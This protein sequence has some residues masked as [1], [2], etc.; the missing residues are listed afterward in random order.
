MVKQGK[1]VVIYLTEYTGNDCLTRDNLKL[2]TEKPNVILVLDYTFFD[3]DTKKDIHVHAVINKANIS[4]VLN[5]DV[6]YFGPANLSG[7]VQ[8]YNMLPAEIRN[9]NL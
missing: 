7:F 3:V 5:D 2:L 9:M 1:T 4:P 8:Y 6:K